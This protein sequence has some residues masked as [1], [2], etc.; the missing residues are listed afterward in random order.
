MP[1]RVPPLAP[2]SIP[3]PESVGI[4]VRFA[5]TRRSALAKLQASALWIVPYARSVSTLAD[6]AC[7]KEPGLTWVNAASQ[8]RS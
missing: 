1:R 6:E 5:A 7:S 4:V 2:F 3:R 8:S